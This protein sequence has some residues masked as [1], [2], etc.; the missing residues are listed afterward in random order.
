MS[1]AGKTP[2]LNYCILQAH[3][4]VTRNSYGII[5]SERGLFPHRELCVLDV[6]NYGAL[7]C[8]V[9]AVEKFNT[10]GDTRHS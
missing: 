1:S 2:R 7:F 5:S 8:L 3:T 10:V 9:R 4:E 6:E